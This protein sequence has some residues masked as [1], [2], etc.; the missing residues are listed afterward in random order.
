[1]SQDKLQNDDNAA[2]TLVSAYNVIPY[3]LQSFSGSHPWHLASIASLCGLQAKD[4]ESCRV[5]ELGCGRGVNTAAMALDLPDSEFVGVDLSKVH[6]EDAQ[7]LSAQ[8]ELKNTSF[9][10]QDIR[11][12]GGEHGK[13]DYILVLGVYSWVPA[14][15]R[16]RILSL[17]KDCLN[18]DGVVMINYSVNPGSLMTGVMREIMLY[19]L[20]QIEHPQD[21]LESSLDF[22]NFLAN[23]SPESS[24]FSGAFSR[25]AKSQADDPQNFYHEHLNIES[26]A[27]YFHEFAHA[28]GVHGLQYLAESSRPEI[29]FDFSPT[30][31]HELAQVPDIVRREQYLDFL[32]NKGAR[33]TMLCH[34]EVQLDRNK[35]K[36][37]LD[38]VYIA[39]AAIPDTEHINPNSDLPVSF[40]IDGIGQINTA[41]PMTKAVM[42]I[43]F[44]SWPMGLRIDDLWNSALELLNARNREIVTANTGEKESLI[45]MLLH[46]YQRGLVYLRLNQ[47]NC[48]AKI[49]ETPEVSRLAQLQ[50]SE[51]G[52][53]VTTQLH[54]TIKLTEFGIH[55]LPLLDGT[56]NRQALTSAMC[57]LAEADEMQVREH[58]EPV[59]DRERL[60]Q[61]IS[62]K[63]ATALE[64]FARCGL[65]IL[66]SHE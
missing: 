53:K 45:D 56:R 12:I 43:L 41:H 25:M 40:K 48:T 57:A 6:I 16:E 62:N 1:M 35:R 51:Y 3:H 26:V 63:V 44:Q 24:G 22:L 15:V 7:K 49:E 59:V 47:P 52:D 50:I 17:C 4:P 58:N 37:L 10:H 54:E 65:L 61:F 23:E 32:L 5:L 34:H 30:L 60:S 29:P 21:R 13:F 14:S 9:H 42:Q 31:K 27:F 18:P 38:R 36:Q 8:L 11:E 39:S 46:S 2:Q 19:H 66:S 33:Q 55:L 28:A 20:H 64:E